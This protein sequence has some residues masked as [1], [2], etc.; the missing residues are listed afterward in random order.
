MMSVGIIDEFDA[1][2][3]NYE[4]KLDGSPLVAPKTRSGDGVIRASFDEAL[5]EKFVSK[6]YGLR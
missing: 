6:Y 2:V 1:K 5:F 4:R 3:I